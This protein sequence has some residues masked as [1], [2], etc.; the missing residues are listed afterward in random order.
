MKIRY[1][2]A[3][4]AAVLALTGCTATNGEPVNGGNIDMND[5]DVQT[6]RETDLSA[7]Y[8][9]FFQYCFG[10]DAAFSYTG[11]DED[12]YDDYLLTYTGKDGVHHSEKCCI[13]NACNIEE[14]EC[15]SS[16]TAWYDFEM[17]SV[18]M[19]ELKK[20]ARTEFMANYLKPY[21]S[22]SVLSDHASCYLDIVNPFMIGQKV[23]L[24]DENYPIGQKLAYQHI[25]SENGVQACSADLNTL[26]QNDEWLLFFQI[27][28]ADDSDA[29]Q[30]TA[31]LQKIYDEMRQAGFRNF[32][33]A[34]RY[35]SGE[36][37][38]KIW[39]QAM[40]LG[41]EYRSDENIIQNLVLRVTEK[42]R[43]A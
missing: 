4:S 40:L 11:S 29:E 42:Y 15:F 24:N 22:D 41:E 37:I 31:S 13:S 10:P 30:M 18:A 21:F 19:A 16:M 7:R 12:N 32:Q 5:L 26:A 20:T 6:V 25:D 14:S 9:E 36:R 2:A 3:V 28:I 34:L 33:I 27:T 38:E 39:S 23:Y 35:R 17:E 43:D 8:P 1:A